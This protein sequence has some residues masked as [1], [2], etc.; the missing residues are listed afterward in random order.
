MN[1][2]SLHLLHFFCIFLE[3]PVYGEFKEIVGFHEKKY[4]FRIENFEVFFIAV[5]HP[6]LNEQKD[7]KKLTVFRNIAT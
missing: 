7:S 3:F 4:D 5:K 6:T 2:V 1:Y